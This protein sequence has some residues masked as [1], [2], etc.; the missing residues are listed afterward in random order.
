MRANYIIAYFQRASNQKML[1]IVV[2]VVV[3]CP[4]QPS[5]TQDEL[6]QKLLQKQCF[7]LFPVIPTLE[8]YF[9]YSLRYHHL[10]CRMQTHLQVKLIFIQPCS[11][12]N[13]LAPCSLELQ[14]RYAAT[15]S[16]LSWFSRDIVSGYLEFSLPRRKFSCPMGSHLSRTPTV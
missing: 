13:L 12:L 1:S 10:G 7:T 9:L 15:E 8:F 2:A 14:I 4:W 5:D 11:P 16:G 3:N 6:F